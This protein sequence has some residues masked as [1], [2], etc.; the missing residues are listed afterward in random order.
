MRLPRDYADW[1][2]YHAA[3]DGNSDG[4]S[5]ARSIMISYGEWAFWGIVIWLA[6]DAIIFLLLYF[7]RD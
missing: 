6:A 5:R 1:I 4:V 2:L 7:R 3:F